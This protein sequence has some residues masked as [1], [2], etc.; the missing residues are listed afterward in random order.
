MDKTFLII[1][2]D[3]NI[4]KMLGF[5]IRKNN[6]G[7]LVGELD[8]GEHGAEE[9][10]FYNPDIVLIDLLL[11][12]KDGIEIIKSAKSQGYKGKF[13]MISQVEDDEM[14]SKAYESGILFFISKPIN[15][16]EAINVIKGVCRNIDLEKSVALIKNTVLNIGV[17]KGD[18]SARKSSLDEEISNI[19]TDIGI[20]GMTGSNELRDIILKIIDIKRRN[21]AANYHLQKIYEEIAKERSL[22]I[23]EPINKRTIE[24]R[25]RRV[26]QKSL[27]TIAEL[28]HDDYYNIKFSEYST[29]L[30][31]FKQVKQEMRHIENPKEEHGKI[32]IKKFIEGII[33]KLNYQKNDM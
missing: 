28:G 10:V 4:R 21:P 30:F 20:I 33:S 19:L 2:D 24:K 22:E 5:L 16:I 8:S 7:K 23:N 18:S 17:I 9:I 1:D 27:Q 13:I 32:S 26:I 3:V 11:P 15:N 29:I 6:L 14:I 25:I 12:V 31:D